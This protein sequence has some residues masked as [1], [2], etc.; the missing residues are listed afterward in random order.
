M[1]I[2]RKNLY[3]IRK[4]ILILLIIIILFISF[5][6]ENKKDIPQFKYNEVKSFYP[7]AKNFILNFNKKKNVEIFLNIKE[8]IKKI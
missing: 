3:F 1:F 2:Q 6:F 5:F 7:D 4:N 8:I